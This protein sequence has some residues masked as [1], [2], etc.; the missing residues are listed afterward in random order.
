MILTNCHRVSQGLPNPSS[1]T[2]HPNSYPCSLTLSYWYAITSSQGMTQ[3]I[4]S[5]LRFPR[6][7]SLSTR[8]PLSIGSSIAH[9]PLP[10]RPVCLSRIADSWAGWHGARRQ[11]L[12]AWPW[13]AGPTWGAWARPNPATV[14]IEWNLYCFAFIMTFAVFLIIYLSIII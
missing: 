11:T 3:P 7:A 13:E 2:S 6:G 4:G 1:Q 10:E 8:S 5:N 12:M 14:A 9:F